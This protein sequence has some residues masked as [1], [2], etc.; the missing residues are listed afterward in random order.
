MQRL[1]PRR[2]ELWLNAGNPRR[3][4]GCPCLMRGNGLSLLLACFPLC[5]LNRESLLSA[6]MDCVLRL[7]SGYLEM[8]IPFFSL[9]LLAGSICSSACSHPVALITELLLS[10]SSSL[11]LLF[12]DDLIFTQQIWYKHIDTTK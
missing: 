11:S 1:R 6:S 8:F 7:L 2:N 9:G 10:S 4:G 12:I 3:V 5:L